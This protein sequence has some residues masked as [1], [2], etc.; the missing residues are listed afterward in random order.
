[1]NLREFNNLTARE[2]IFIVISSTLLFLFAGSIDLAEN[3]IS[4][5]R[6]VEVVDIDEIFPV[7]FYLVLVLSL[8]A[9][10]RTREAKEALREAE[11]RGVLLQAALDEIR[12]LKGIIP[13]CSACKKIRD[14]EGY[15]HQVELYIEQHTGAQFSHGLCPTCVHQL[16]PEYAKS[17]DQAL[18]KENQ[19]DLF[20]PP[21]DTSAG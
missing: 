20:I 3:L 21:D 15:W 17:V 12:Q 7:S 8:F 5:V 19:L 11:A 16:Y 2:V 6:K 14:D 4:T 1:M 10:R 13:M 9:M 18:K